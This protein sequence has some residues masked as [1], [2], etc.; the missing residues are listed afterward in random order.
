M[1]N[2]FETFRAEMERLGFIS[3]PQRGQWRHRVRPILVAIAPNYPKRPWCVYVRSRLLHANGDMIGSGP[4]RRFAS[5]VT[6]ARAAL[7]TL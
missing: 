2:T 1:T 5:P 4:V 7:E 6:A 3:E